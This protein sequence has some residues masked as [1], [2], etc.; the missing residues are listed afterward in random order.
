MPDWTLTLLLA[1]LAALPGLYA[2]FFREPRKDAAAI[3]KTAA[4]AG[5]I[6]EETEALKLERAEKLAAK[7][8]ELEARIEA[9]EA[10][11]EA[12]EL[13]VRELWDENTLLRQENGELRDWAERLVKQVY[14]LGAKPVL[15]RPAGAAP[16]RKRVQPGG[17]R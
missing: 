1:A 14:R 15:L 4:E 12:L 2:A 17:P 13:Q 3:H 8:E 9:L 16:I 10:R 5:R 6:E 7:V 11:I